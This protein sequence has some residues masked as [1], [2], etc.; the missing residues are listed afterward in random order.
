MCGVL[1]L[2]G[3]L[4]VA[5]GYDLTFIMARI[6]SRAA[7]HWSQY[8]RAFGTTTPR[9]RGSREGLILLQLR[10]RTCLPRA[11]GWILFYGRNGFGGL[12][13]EK[14]ICPGAG[15]GDSE[16]YQRRQ[17]PLPC[18]ADEAERRPTARGTFPHAGRWGLTPLKRP[19]SN[20]SSGA[21]AGTKQRAGPQREPA[22]RPSSQ[23]ATRPLLLEQL[24]GRVVGR[25]G[26]VVDLRA[27]G[28]GRVLGARSRTARE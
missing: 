17:S 20:R 4:S 27:E 13:R 12:G 1:G 15:P 6:Q 16:R 8:A 5:R 18:H 7:R 21:V 14:T 11:C 25:D 2:S 19:S 22:L 23:A 9:S 28:V 24:D 3:H 10:D 26:H